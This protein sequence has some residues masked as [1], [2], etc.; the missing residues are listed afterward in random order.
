MK[1]TI[2][3]ITT[4]LAALGMTAA[5]HTAHAQAVPDCS[6]T[7]V[8]PTALDCAGYRVGDHDGLVGGAFVDTVLGNWGLTS[9]TSGAG[10][11][12]LESTDSAS[13]GFDFSGSS[14]TFGQ[15]VYGDA[16]VGLQFGVGRQGQANA[17]AIYHLDAGVAGLSGFSFDN[18]TMGELRNVSLWANANVAAVP[19]P[20]TYALML[21]GLA[22]V[23]AARRRRGK[24]SI[25]LTERVEP[26]LG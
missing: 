26:R 1:T 23:V 2:R 21:V 14:V 22:A 24:G 20:Q 4:A 13:D 11:E 16:V 17:F 5:M 10:F 3:T 6:T 8:N 25:E 15:M 7:D 18:P 19:E 12:E 9:F